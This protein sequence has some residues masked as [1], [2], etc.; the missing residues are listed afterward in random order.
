MFGT[1]ARIELE[2]GEFVQSTGML[3]LSKRA[4]IPVDC[5]HYLLAVGLVRYWNK[6]ASADNT[7][8]SCCPKKA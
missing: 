5:I 3:A 8:V 6:G 7:T 4:S 2:T 1:F